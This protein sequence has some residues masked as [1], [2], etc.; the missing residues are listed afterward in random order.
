MARPGPR[1]PGPH[2]EKLMI[3]LGKGLPGPC[4]HGSRGLPI[5]PQKP[6]RVLRRALEADF[7]MQVRSGRAAARAGL[8]DLAPATHDRAFFDQHLRKMRIPADE[9]VAVVDV[10][11][12]TVLRVIAGEL[13]HSARG[14]DDRRPG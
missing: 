5:R 8:G 7:E 4:R 2:P 12:V 13:N 14:G 6:H 3:L 10:D 9:I 11:Y 1:Y